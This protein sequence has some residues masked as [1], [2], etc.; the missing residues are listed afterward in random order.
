MYITVAM[1]APHS[2]SG[3]Q[4][5]RQRTANSSKQVDILTWKEGRMEKKKGGKLN[6]CELLRITIYASRELGQ[7]MRI[8]CQIFIW[9]Y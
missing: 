3:G 7:R 4:R 2:S 5:R 6:H 8:Y 1:S 9:G